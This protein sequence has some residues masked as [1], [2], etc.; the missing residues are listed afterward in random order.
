[1][2]YIKQTKNW[3]EQFVIALNL[4]PFAKAPFTTDR[5]RYQVCETSS[6]KEL[7][8]VLLAECQRLRQTS[9]QEIET[10]LIIHP[11]VL[12]DFRAYLHFLDLA[13]ELLRMSGFE[14]I[15]QIASFHPQYQ[16]ATTQKGD[17]ENYTN[18]SPFPIL[19]L[20]REDSLTT[21]LDVFPNPEQIPETNIQLLKKMGIDQIQLLLE[22]TIVE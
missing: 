18:R 16:F 12:Q 22:K 9:P 3:L 19:H 1:M 2:N 20:L 10:T 17:V 5:I 7:L 15:F 14:G 8:Q 4:C 21:V 13:N 11:N 6:E